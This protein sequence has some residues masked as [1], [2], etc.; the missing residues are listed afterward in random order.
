MDNLALE[1][2]CNIRV[3]EYFVKECFALKM[4][5]WSLLTN[6]WAFMDIIE[7]N[8]MLH[9]EILVISGLCC[10][11]HRLSGFC[12]NIFVAIS[13]MTMQCMCVQYLQHILTACQPV[14]G[15]ITFLFL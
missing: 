13:L 6:P 3:K 11:C 12:L 9:Y 4:K 10:I 15:A 14:G 2:V 7:K 8:V 1:S 5:N